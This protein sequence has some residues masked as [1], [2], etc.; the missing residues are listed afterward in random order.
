MNATGKGLQILFTFF[1]YLGVGVGAAL[2]LL[3]SLARPV[4]LK[5]AGYIIGFPL[6]VFSALVVYWTLRRNEAEVSSTIVLDSWDAVADGM[7]NSNTDLIFWKGAYYLI[8]AAA[9]Y[10]LG[11]SDCRLVVWRS[12]D[13]RNWEQLSTL[14]AAPDDIRDPKFAVIQDRL[15]LYALKNE[16]WNPEPYTSV[17]T[18]SL[19]GVHW[20][21]FQEIEP[22]G[23]LFWKPK[24][25]DGLIYY[26]P[27]YW[28]EHGKSALFSSSDGLH[29]S[30]LS[31]IYSGDRNDETDIEFLPDGRM[32]ATARLEFSESILGHSQGCTLIATSNRPYDAWQLQAKSPVTRLDGPSLFRYQD[33]VYAVGRF[34]PVLRGPF[35][36]MGSV[37]ARKRTSLFRVFEDR[38]VRLTDLPS[39]GD[40]AYSGVV[41]QGDELFVSYY[42]SDIRKDYVWVAGMLSPSSIRMAR[43]SLSAMDA[44]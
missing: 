17:V 22:K 30:Q 38:L 39:A 2:V 33:R 43:V 28:W 44:L 34:Q 26:V 25:A 4:P 32:I 7:H 3:A 24:T 20:D 16:S 11:S 29:W 21:P 36:N 14:Q 10:H 42:T 1:R 23:W 8:H 40:T 18:T 35:S 27:A 5:L 12:P 37:F 15:F 19:D 41:V 9:P 13:A 31:E 6:L